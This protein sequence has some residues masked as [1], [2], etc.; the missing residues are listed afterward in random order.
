MACAA[1]ILRRLAQPRELPRRASVR[2]SSFL[3]LQRRAASSIGQAA[4]SAGGERLRSSDNNDE[5]ALLFCE[6]FKGMEEL[7]VRRPGHPERRPMTS[8]LFTTPAGIKS[9]ASLSSSGGGRPVRSVTSARSLFPSTDD[10]FP[11][12]RAPGMQRAKTSFFPV[13][14]T[15]EPK[16]AGA[17]LDGNNGNNS[18]QAQ[19]QSPSL[20]R[21]TTSS[22]GQQ[23][24]A[25]KS[26]TATTDAHADAQS[27]VYAYGLWQNRNAGLLQMEADMQEMASKARYLRGV[28]DAALKETM[29]QTTRF[30]FYVVFPFVFLVCALLFNE[31]ALYSSQLQHL[32]LIN[33]DA[34]LASKEQNGSRKGGFASGGS[35]G[36]ALGRSKQGR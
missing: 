35:G 10:L 16:Q 29:R 24:P 14:G 36:G 2:P 31:S 3:A 18:K 9:S 23:M 7:L 8:P 19:T 13:S 5:V 4:A 21:S 25:D 17:D 6:C 33:Y 12:L 32:C 22:E 20:G 28:Q 1:T 15:L 30:T 11:D 26:A 27:Y 34:W